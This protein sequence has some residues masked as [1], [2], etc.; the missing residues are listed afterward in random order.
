MDWEEG[1]KRFVWRVKRARR[2]QQFSESLDSA[3]RQLERL[4]VSTILKGFL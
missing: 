3:V 2:K 4:G 1:I